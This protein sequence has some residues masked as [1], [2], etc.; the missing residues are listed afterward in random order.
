MKIKLFSFVSLL[1]LSVAI[2]AQSQSYK[3]LWDKVY[4]LEKKDLPTSVIKVTEQIYNKARKENNLGEALKAYQL[5]MKYREELSP[6]S[7]YIDLKQLEAWTTNELNPANKAVLHSVLA[8]VYL[9]AFDNLVYKIPLQAATTSIAPI[10]IRQWTKKDFIE[11]ILKSIRLSMAEPTMQQNTSSTRFEPLAV[12]EPTSK[13]FRHSLFDLLGR[14]A[15]S[16]LDRLY[17]FT[18]DTYPQTKYSVTPQMTQVNEFVKHLYIPKSSY[19]IVAESFS[20]YQAML[21]YYLKTDN[22]DAIVLTDLDL[23]KYAANHNESALYVKAL[24]NLIEKYSSSPVCAEVYL[25]KANYFRQKK[26][27]LNALETARQGIAQYP[28]YDR[29]KALRMVEK[30]LLNPSLTISF[31]K[32]IYPG[33]NYQL[34]ANHVNENGFTLEYYL[35]KPTAV[36]LPAHAK[37]MKKQY[38]SLRKPTDLQET[39]TIINLCAPEAGKYMVRVVPDSK[40]ELEKPQIIYI[41]KLRSIT[42][43]YPNAA[44]EVIIVDNESG[45]P[46]PDVTVQ[47]FFNKKKDEKKASEMLTDKTGRAV[48]PDSKDISSFSFTKGNDPG[49]GTE[50]LPY[51]SYGSLVQ[52]WEEHTHLIT[53]RNIYRPG[54][55]V[56]VKGIVYTQLLDS[57]HAIANKED[58]LIL[59]DANYQQISEKKVTTNEFGSFT[60][61]FILPASCLNGNFSIAGK[62]GNTSFAV[63]DYKRPSFDISFRPQA[64]SY[65]LGDSIQVCGAVK[66]FSGVPLSGIKASYT[67][68]RVPIFI[69]RWTRWTNPSII[70]SGEQTLDGQGKFDIG[71]VLST[72]QDKEKRYYRYEVKVTVTNLAGETQTSETYI[73]AGSKSMYF[74]CDLPDNICKE[75]LPETTIKAF[76]LEQQAITLNG[77]YQVLHLPDSVSVSKGEFSTSKPLNLAAISTLANGEYLLRYKGINSQQ[78]SITDENKFILFSLEDKKPPIVTPNWFVLLDKTFTPKKPATALFGSSEKDV[79]TIVDFYSDNKK[80][81]THSIYLSDTVQRITI[82]C[83]AEMKT[84]SMQITFV[85][86]GKAYQNEATVK[87]ELPSKELSLKWDVFRDKLRP[88]QE[89]EWKLTINRPN[90]KPADAEFLAMM[91]D[92]SLDKLSSSRFLEFSNLA[93]YIPST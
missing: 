48:S 30:E 38:V 52:S 55:T 18:V 58:V 88:G 2:S 14:R 27:H 36:L 63:A 92:A 83:E 31:P 69:G 45:Q 24:D 62:Y 15:I 85:K 44:A 9:R 91:Y 51:I 86:N 65:R 33:I 75:R 78:D 74:L 23:L 29:V 7:F 84:V 56:K 73:A 72:S 16:L 67:I 1:L 61:E 87:Q 82:P 81:I 53:D 80:S 42:R 28:R 59:R 5:R 50:R 60:A 40:V 49:N 79:Y 76:N 32:T 13:Y 20:V 4:S 71:F 21:T 17:Y 12:I 34:K 70:N 35:V 93:K 3:K 64:T 10:D 8:E 11:C 41:S 46:V 77:E 26:E 47:F 90:G 89:E 43:R 25:A 68:T 22:R 37:P 66:T 19:D 54:Q 39:D 57:A 6:D